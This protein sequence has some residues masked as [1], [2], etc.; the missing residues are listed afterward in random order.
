LRSSARASAR[1]PANV[2]WSTWKSVDPPAVAV[3]A[4]SIAGAV[5]A[6]LL[7]R[8][9]LIFH[10]RLRRRLD[11]GGGGDGDGGQRRRDARHGHR[12]RLDPLSVHAADV[13]ALGAGGVDALGLVGAGVQLGITRQEEAVTG[14]LTRL[15]GIG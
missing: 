15:S 5:G 7:Q 6:M 4:L 2:F 8:Y 14:S 1:W 9:V 12:Q 11:D 3:I 10:H 13:S